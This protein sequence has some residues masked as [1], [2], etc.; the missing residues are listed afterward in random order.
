MSY[1]FGSPHTSRLRKNSAAA[2]GLCPL[3]YHAFPSF[4]LKR[5]MY[6]LHKPHLL[7]VWLFSVYMTQWL[8][9]Q[10]GH[11]ACVNN[12]C[13]QQSP[14][15]CSYSICLHT[16]SL[17]SL[18]KFRWVMLA[19]AKAILL[20]DIPSASPPW[21]DGAICHTAVQHLM[22]VQSTWYWRQ[23]SQQYIQWDRIFLKHLYE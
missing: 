5:L 1:S 12:K 14:Q 18:N 13:T 23:A 2:T 22:P 4:A 3:P 6:S 21:D 17:K 8:H 7:H 9:K 11:T 15:K 20:G 16:G 10:Q 19:R